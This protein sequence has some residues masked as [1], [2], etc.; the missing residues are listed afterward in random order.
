M[1]LPPG[2]EP[3]TRETAITLGPLVRYLAVLSACLSCAPA[4]AVEGQVSAYIDLSVGHS[5][6]QH[7]NAADLNFD[8]SV[9]GTKTQDTDSAL[10]IAIGYGFSE[11]FT[12]EFGHLDLGQVTAQGTSDGSGGYW[13]DG[14]VRY[15]AESRGYDLGAVGR[16]PISESLWIVGRAGVLMWT[17]T[18]A[19]QDSTGSG[20]RE[21][22]GSDAFL[23]LGLELRLSPAVSFRG[24]YTRYAVDYL[25][26]NA[27]S[28]SV[29]LRLP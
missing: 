16:L 4:A 1:F 10:R 2:A 12:I 24:D 13:A 17:L 27:A 5:T 21:Y 26:I 3:G 15:T 9:S 28:A 19:A 11:Y 20:K 18:T 6:V 22:G 8:Q 25:D 23:G 29:I 14:P 7:W